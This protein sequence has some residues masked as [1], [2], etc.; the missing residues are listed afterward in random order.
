MNLEHVFFT[1]TAYIIMLANTLLVSFQYLEQLMGSILA[2]WVACEVSLV[3]LVEV[4]CKSLCTLL[5]LCLYNC[6]RSA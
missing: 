4:N 6:C 3:A 1:N 5:Q 2:S